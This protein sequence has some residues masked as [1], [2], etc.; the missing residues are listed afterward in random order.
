MSYRNLY[1]A[2]ENNGVPEWKFCRFLNYNTAIFA[3][4][5]ITV[6]I[7]T[8]LFNHNTKR[9]NIVEQHKTRQDRMFMLS[10]DIHRSFGRP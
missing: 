7:F 1:E 6:I 3:V 8:S 9:P 10:V 2:K 5:S 4:N